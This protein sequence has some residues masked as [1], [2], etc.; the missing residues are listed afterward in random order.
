MDPRDSIENNFASRIK[1]Y[2]QV[3]TAVGG[4]LA[5]IAGDRYL[6]FDIDGEEHS[7]KI[8]ESLGQLK[9]PLMKVA[10]MLA[11]IPDMLP[12]AYA[13]ALQELQANAPSM[14]WL[15][16]KRRMKAELGPDWQSKFKEFEHQACAA[17]SLGQVHK[18][19]DLAGNHLA[20]K[21]QYPD[22]GSAVQADLGQ[23]KFVLSVY[24]KSGGPLSTNELYKEVSERLYEE[25]D[26]E[27]EAKHMK[28]FELMLKGLPFAHIPQVDHDL[29]TKRL[30]SMNWLEGRRMMDMVDEPEN[31]RNK[32]AEHMFRL[33]Y[34]PLYTYGVIHGD[35]HLGNYTVREDQ[36][37]NLLDFG[38]IRIFDPTFVQGVIELYK[39]LRDSKPD[40]TVAAYEMWGFA[41]L[42]N[43]HIEVLNLW[44]GYLYG[45][46]LDDRV[47]P[48]DDKF[49]GI[50]GKEAAGEVFSKLRKIG[51]VTPPREF[52]FMDRAAVGIGSVLLH[53]K[54][55]L[56]WH[57][58]FEEL[59]EGFDVETMAVDQKTVLGEADLV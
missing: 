10:Q 48:I 25:L 15:F 19:Q 26:Y 8:K 33:W 36:G 17:A 13:Q 47:R 27:L 38:C 41:N 7:E 57:Q 45:P 18:A 54:A 2:A 28:L 4:L 16:V 32:V 56:N 51:G 55:S 58:M 50:A 12:P 22:M 39:S 59:I 44:A 34:S 52:V 1:R 11:T 20:C 43:E 37:I 9:G 30:L 21:L 6:G 49:S 23:L 42:T 53:L 46:L 31:I 14:G 29:S 24:E 35:P 5:R 3:S 40:Q